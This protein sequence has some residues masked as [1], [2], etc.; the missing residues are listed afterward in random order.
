MASYLHHKVQG[1]PKDGVLKPLAV[2]PSTHSRAAAADTLA[3]F[4]PLV[5]PMTF[6]I[7]ITTTLISLFESLI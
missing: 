6:K 1:D 5:V 2:V 4:K 3:T 7:L